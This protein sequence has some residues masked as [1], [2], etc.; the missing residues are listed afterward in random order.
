M[1]IRSIFAGRMTAAITAC[2]LSLALLGHIVPVP[3]A[4]ARIAY[5]GEPA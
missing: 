4:E 3:Q 2:A 5:V 1:Q